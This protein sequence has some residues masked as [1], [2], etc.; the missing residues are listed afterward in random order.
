ML[1][2]LS[3]LPFECW[4]R[5]GTFDALDEVAEQ[6]QVSTAMAAFHLDL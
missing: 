3:F 5:Q 1:F 4:V 6:E 2:P